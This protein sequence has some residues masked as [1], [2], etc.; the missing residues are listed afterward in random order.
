MLDFHALASEAR[1]AAS[2]AFE[3]TGPLPEVPADLAPVAGVR[4]LS[5]TRMADLDALYDETSAALQFPDYFGRNL[6]ALDECLRDLDLPESPG[7]TVILV[8]TD[9]AAMLEAEP[10]RREWFGEAVADANEVRAGRGTGPLVVVYS[11]PPGTDPGDR[12]WR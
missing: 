1:T 11:V 10:G 7:G 5:G 4:R 3:V 12:W 8:V 6:D 9:A 2:S